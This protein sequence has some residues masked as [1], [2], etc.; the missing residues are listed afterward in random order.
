VVKRLVIALPPACNLNSHGAGPSERLCYEK[1]KRLHL[2]TAKLSSG[3]NTKADR[4]KKTRGAGTG[5]AARTSRE[6]Q[7]IDC[8]KTGIPPAVAKRLAEKL[9]LLFLCL[10]LRRTLLTENTKIERKIR[11]R[12]P[13]E[14][15]KVKWKGCAGV[16]RA[17]RTPAPPP[18]KFQPRKKIVGRSYYFF[19]LSSP[20]SSFV[21]FSL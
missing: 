6:C 18:R 15:K 20:P 8:Q 2:S 12:K 21:S 3:S 1:K 11:A 9:R 16:L 5:A 17:E 14:R 7:R 13:G 10:S 19:F 4:A